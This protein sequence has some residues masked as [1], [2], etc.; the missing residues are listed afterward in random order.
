[1]KAS[2]AFKLF[3]L[4]AGIPYNANGGYGIGST[5]QTVRE[6]CRD[7]KVLE[8]YS[9]RGGLERD[10]QLLV[11]KGERADQIEEDVKKWLPKLSFNISNNGK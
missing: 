8:G 5:F 4:V 11:L 6:L 10:G 3:I 1:M 2:D 9:T 7:S